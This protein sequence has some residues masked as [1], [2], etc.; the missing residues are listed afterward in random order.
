MAAA[1]IWDKIEEVI[2]EIRPAI[3]ADGGDIELVSFDEEEGRVELRLVGACHS[4]PYSLMTLK[5]GIEHRLRSRLP[6]VKTVIA[7]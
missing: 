1:T 2:A 7:L 3:R 6:E 4:C 5:G